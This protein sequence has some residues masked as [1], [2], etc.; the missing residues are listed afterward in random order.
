MSYWSGSSALSLF[1]GDLVITLLIEPVHFVAR[2]ALSVAQSPV[3]LVGRWDAWL[4]SFHPLL[5]KFRSPAYWKCDTH[6]V[7]NRA[8]PLCS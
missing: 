1:L 4:T 8:R 7:S 2:A 5:K 3:V 6:S